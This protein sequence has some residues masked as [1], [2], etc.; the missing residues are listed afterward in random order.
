ME[1]IPPPIEAFVNKVFEGDCLEIMPTIPDH[2]VDMILC[3]LPYGVTKNKWD[4]VIDFD[5][6]WG[7]YTRI[8]KPNGAIVLTSQGLFTAELILSKRDWFRYKIV[9]IK[10]S[11]R[12]FLNAKKQPLRKHE[13]ICVFY[14]KQ[15]TY[16]PQMSQGEPYDKGV[17]H[18]NQS[19]CYGTYGASHSKSDGARYPLDVVGFD[20]VPD[21]IYTNTAEV[22]GEARH[23]TQK[24]VELGRYL[25][26]TYTNKGDVVLD[27]CCGSGSFLVAAALEGRKYIGIELNANATTK[28]DIPAD[29][30]QICR[31]RLE[32]AHRQYNENLFNQ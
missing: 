2:S 31:K 7:Q 3:D 4:T 25:I 16:H 10:S 23:P 5:R 17:N 32:E 11:A 21:Y 12:G 1:I 13:D 9:W 19:S 15:P 27:N 8:I 26:R 24:P 14:K 18:N 20:E 6:L 29:Y 30:V 22:E 28:K